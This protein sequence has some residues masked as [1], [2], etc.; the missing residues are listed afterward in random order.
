MAV[1]VILTAIKKLISPAVGGHEAETTSGLTQSLQAN[2]RSYRDLMQRDTVYQDL[3]TKVLHYKDAYQL[4]DEHADQSFGADLP[5]Q[6]VYLEFVPEGLSLMLVLD[7]TLCT[8]HEEDKR[9]TA[10]S[11]AAVHRAPQA[12]KSL[13]SVSDQ[14]T[15][16]SLVQFIVSLGI[17][18]YLSPLLDSL[19]RVRLSHAKMVEKCTEEE[20][21]RDERDH[22]LYKSCRVLVRCFEN[23]VLG[24]NLISQHF[25]DVLAALVQTCYAPR[26]SSQ[27][28][29]RR[30]D[31]TEHAR[32]KQQCS[33]GDIKVKDSEAEPSLERET[34]FISLSEREW[35]TD[36][37]RKLLNKTYQP[38]VVRELLI[39][40]KMA[41][42]GH[43][44]ARGTDHTHTHL[45]LLLR[46][47]TCYS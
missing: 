31:S 39:L 30:G 27:S 25:S 36:A 16:Q 26:G 44:T 40:Q 3:A 43:P 4:T 11:A 23:P 33:P 28:T 42:A 17:F 7:E 21:S 34:V 45:E 32:T 24:P 14:K 29:R 19:L 35:C 38:L 46:V 8:L 2:L 10:P 41:S 15:V 9:S 13:L 1:K 12:P 37:L 20:M 18:P 6:E 22:Y 5:A 47:L